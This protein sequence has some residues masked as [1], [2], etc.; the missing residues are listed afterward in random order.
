MNMKTT[1]T[2]RAIRVEKWIDAV[3]KNF[4]DAAHTKI[5]GLDCE[6]TDPRKPNQCAAVLQLSVAYETLVFHICHADEVPQ[7]LKDFLADEKIYFCG[8]AIGNDV[9][10]LK[11]YG[12]IIPS[13]ID[14]QKVLVNPTQKL[15]PSLYDL[16]NHYLGT[17][18]EKTKKKKN[19]QMTAE[20]KALIFGWADFPLSHAQVEYAA[21]DARLGFELGR[22]HFM[23][24]DYNIN[25]DRL[26]LNIY[27]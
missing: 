8:A 12:I 14:L 17:K 20:E 27:E 4:L 18:L 23:S 11:T 2:L 3:K 6:F 7:V 26:N 22:R 25:D 16:A 15:L 13:A 19:N 21:L 24:P 9:N 1:V 5:V 10:M